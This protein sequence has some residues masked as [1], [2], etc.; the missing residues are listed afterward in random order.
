MSLGTYGELAY[1]ELPDQYDH[2]VADPYA[3]LFADPYIQLL[4]LVELHP[5]D[6]EIL[7]TLIGNPPFGAT[8][9]GEYDIEIRGAF[10]AVYLSD[11]G[12]TTDPDSS[13]SNTHFKALVDNPLQYDVSII[14]GEEF[15]NGGASFGSMVI[16]NGD[17]ALDDKVNLYWAGRRAVVKAGTREVPYDAFQTV[18]DGSVAD[19]ESTDQQI[20][21]TIQDNR[22]KID[23]YLDVGTYAGT[24]GLEGGADI[25]RKPKPL[26][27]GAIFNVEPILVDPVNLIYQVNDGAVISID[28]VRDSGVELTWDADVADITA[29]TPSAGEF[30]TQ[31]SGGYIK[32]GSTPAG[33]ITAD[34]LASNDNT[35]AE[36]V[37][38]VVQTRLGANSLTTG[39]IDGGAFGLLAAGLPGA[40]GLYISE[41]ATATEV[42]DRLL[43]PCAAYW[44]F[45]RAGQ[46]TCG[47]IDGPGAETISY[48]L[49]DIEFDGLEQLAA[50]TPTWR[51]TVGYAPL[52]VV[53]GE[54]ELAGA[55]TDADR[56]FLGQG[57]R[58]VSSENDYVRV[59]NPQA[60]ERTFLTQLRD[61]A[62]AEA[63]LVRLR[64]V[65]EAQRRTFR[66]PLVK[67][68][69]RAAIGDTVKVT[70]PRH[71]LHAGQNFRVV[72][73]SED[74]ESRSTSLVLWG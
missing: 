24:G 69:F 4:F 54:D 52:G 61:K 13:L 40:M 10:S 68:L 35:A 71:Q 44:T 63:L 49:N 30:A 56:A 65:Y 67:S 7:G 43:L 16:H 60:R 11:L 59:I 3:G 42:L 57:F 64:S 8:A 66:V 33:R 46:L 53:Q 6:P 2:S 21:L 73:V 47:L 5:Y 31:I 22:G 17:G 29:A 27:L 19:I 50:I 39:E 26:C 15:G 18:F 37:Q 20:T 23:Q 51:I 12:Y 70:Y 45:T 62:D 48:D 55:A 32:L 58:T 25:A 34:V 14:S 74:A 1:A 38:Q 72:G 9:Y 41:R 28:K 36:L